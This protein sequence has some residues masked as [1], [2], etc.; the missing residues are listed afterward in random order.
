MSF[1]LDA[2]VGALNH[3]V[4]EAQRVAEVQHLALMDDFFDTDDTGVRTARS[5]KVGVPSLTDA[6]QEVIDVPLVTLIP[7]SSLTIKDLSISFRARLLEAE[8]NET[9]SDDSAKSALGGAASHTLLLDLK[10]P[11]MMSNP[12]FADV[13]VTFQAGD[14]P[15]GLVRINDR[16]LKQIP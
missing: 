15:E 12:I 7:I 3:A 8:V 4:V 13:Q 14:P 6:S 11:R 16:I 2:L 10:A 5:V 1:S 9:E